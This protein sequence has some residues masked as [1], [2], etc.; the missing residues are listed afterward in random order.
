MTLT[1]LAENCDAI[2]IITEWNEFKQLDL[3]R[4]YQ[5]MRTPI[6]LDGRNIYDPTIMRD[7]G[8]HYRGFGRGYNS[9][10]GA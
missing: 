1:F 3:V 2:V 5:R 10:Q 4:I 8:F 6:I 9:S 7:L